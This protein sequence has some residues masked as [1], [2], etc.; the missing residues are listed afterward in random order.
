MCTIKKKKENSFSAPGK[1]VKGGKNDHY[2]GIITGVVHVLRERR[3]DLQQA[4]YTLERAF[5]PARVTLQRGE[6]LG[7]ID[8][9]D[10]GRVGCFGLRTRFWKEERES[11]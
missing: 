6:K 3:F 8:D 5:L 10:L 9:V 4:A 1:G 2:P 7:C 11:V